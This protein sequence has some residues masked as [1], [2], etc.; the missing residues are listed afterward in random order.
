MKF[1]IEG[2]FL[3]SHLMTVNAE[4][5]TRCRRAVTL[6]RGF[7]PLGARVGAPAPPTGAR[8]DWSSGHSRG[9]VVVA[10]CGLGKGAW[11]GFHVGLA[12][13]PEAERTPAEHGF[14]SRQSGLQYKAVER[15]KGE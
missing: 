13:P 14:R 10:R 1:R 12:N 11:P 15:R 2:A 3:H 4:L 7:L 9:P 5:S 8:R 6:A